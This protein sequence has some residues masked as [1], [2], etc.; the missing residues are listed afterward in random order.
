MKSRREFL[1]LTATAG[2]AIA[3]TPFIAKLGATSAPLSR[4]GPA[5]LRLSLSAMSF[6]KNF[7][8]NRG[9][10]VE[11]SPAQALDLFKFIDYCAAHGC[12]GAE[13]TTYF[14]PEETE[15]Y[16]AKL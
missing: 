13:P 2:A 1:K 5:R 8:V 12:E 7:T 14:F 3:A 11:V 4:N 10:K 15:E 16:M 9:K 6:S